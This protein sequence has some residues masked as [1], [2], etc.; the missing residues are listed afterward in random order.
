M[1]PQSFEE[2]TPRF[3]LENYFS[4]HTRGYGMFYDRFG[5]VQLNFT[6]DLEGKWESGVLTLNETLKYEDG[7]E[8]HRTYKITKVNENLY[9]VEC[10]DLI[11]KATIESYGNTLKW[12]YNLRQLIGSSYWVLSF[13]DWMFLKDDGV[14]LNRAYAKKF[15]VR[16][17]EVFISIRKM[18]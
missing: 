16:I 8:F 17:G 2:T 6:A 15:G 5:H 3:I 10:P 1:K 4:G 7:R 12:T 11:G 13:D 18:E 14:V 9:N